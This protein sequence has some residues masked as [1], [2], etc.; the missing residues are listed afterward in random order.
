MIV[1]LIAHTVV[2]GWPAMERAGWVENDYTLGGTRAPTVY[3]PDELAEFAGRLCYQSWNRPNPATA[4]NAGY[5]AHILE[6]GHYSVLEHASATFYVAEVSRS[7][8]HELVRH[9]HLSF[10]QLSQRYVDESQA[11][12]VTPPAIFKEQGASMQLYAAALTGQRDFYKKIVEYLVRAGYTRKEAR[13]AARAVLPNATATRFV[14]TGNLRAWREVVQKRI[15]PAADAEMQAF[16][17]RV[18]DHLRQIAPG[19][20]QDFVT[21]DPRAPTEAGASADPHASDYERFGRVDE[22][23]HVTYDYE[24]EGLG[25]T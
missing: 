23:G 7:L 9:R 1:E 2:T 19:T 14:V 6:V 11:Q 22:Q 16:A 10:S 15:A 3:P 13:Q 8:S 12:F 17:R 20:F 4:T 21:D 5:L 24:T 25:G 18:L